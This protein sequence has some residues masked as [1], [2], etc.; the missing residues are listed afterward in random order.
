MVIEGSFVVEFW[1]DAVKL[2]E[3]EA[4]IGWSLLVDMSAVHHLQEVIIVCAFFQVFSDT[5]ELLEVD[6][7]VFIGIE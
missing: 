1:D 7:T 3:S 5:L 4:L 2:F 6:N